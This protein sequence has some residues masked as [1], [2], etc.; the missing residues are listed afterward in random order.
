MHVLYPD[1]YTSLLNFPNL[2]DLGDLRVVDV[3][4]GWGCWL[5][6]VKE[7][8]TGDDDVH[9]GGGVME[10]DNMVIDVLGKGGM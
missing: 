5:L 3:W 2:F 1:G 6:T 10:D 7:M 8:C 9:C 4:M